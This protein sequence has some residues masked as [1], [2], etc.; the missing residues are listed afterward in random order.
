VPA[1]LANFE[2][3]MALY[4]LIRG[5][6]TF[7]DLLYGGCGTCTQAQYVPNLSLYNWGSLLKTLGSTAGS[8]APTV[9]AM[10]AGHTHASD[11]YDLYSRTFVGGQAWFNM[12]G[13]N[14]TIAAPANAK[15]WNGNPVTGTF[16]LADAT[17]E[18]LLFRTS[19]TA[20]VPT[21]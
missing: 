20:A 14:Q 5:P 11:G 13:A 21:R 2:T 9:V 18:V 10:A 3:A 6:N 7:V 8:S 12:T 15:D 4:L 17:G 16:T 1:T 19:A